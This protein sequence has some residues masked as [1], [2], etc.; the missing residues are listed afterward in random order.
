MSS[1]KQESCKD[2]FAGLVH[3]LET[4]V[5]GNPNW[6]RDIGNGVTDIQLARIHDNPTF[7]GIDSNPGKAKI[8]L[9]YI[10]N[11]ILIIGSSIP[12]N[13]CEIYINKKD[14]IP[15]DKRFSLIYLGDFEKE[16][17]P[18][19]DKDR[20]FTRKGLENFL[21]DKYN[22]GEPDNLKI[23]TDEEM[24]QAEIV[25]KANLEN[26]DF[27]RIVKEEGPLKVLIVSDDEQ[28]TLRGKEVL[29]SLHQNGHRLF[30]IYNINTTDFLKTEDYKPSTLRL[31]V[32][33]CDWRNRS[34]TI[35]SSSGLAFLNTY[36]ARHKKLY[37]LLVVNTKQN[38]LLG[39]SSLWDSLQRIVLESPTKLTHAIPYPRG[40]Q[41]DP[42]RDAR[43]WG[44]LIKEFLYQP[45]I[46]TLY[47]LH[48]DKKDVR[49]SIANLPVQWPLFNA[50]IKSEY[51]SKEIILESLERIKGWDPAGKEELLKSL[52]P[53][54][55]DFSLPQN[56]YPLPEQLGPLKEEEVITVLN[57]TSLDNP[58][59]YIHVPFCKKKCIYCDYT[60]IEGASKK[61]LEAYLKLLIRE[62]EIFYRS[63]GLQKL[64]PVSIQFGGG[65][66]TY[67]TSPLIKRLGKIAEKYLDLS[68]CKEITFETTPTTATPGKLDAY[69]TIGANRCSIGLQ[70][71]V[72]HLN[73]WSNR[74]YPSKIAE[75]SVR[76]VMKRW[77]NVNIDFMYGFPGQTP[78][79]WVGDLEQIISM[80]I[81]SIHCYGLRRTDKTDYPPSQEFPGIL[82]RM[83]MYV[84]AVELLTNAGYSQISDSNFVLDPEK[85]AYIYKHNKKGGN[86][87]IGIGLSSYSTIFGTSSDNGLFYFNLGGKDNRCSSNRRNYSE[88]LKKG[89]LPIE[90]GKVLDLDDKMKMF[91][92]QGLKLSGVGDSATGIDTTEFEN[93]YGVSLE[94]K[95]PH[96]KDL[97]DAGLLE[98][99]GDHISLS[100]SGLAFGDLVLKTYLR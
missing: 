90:I 97:L 76:E 28:Y 52:Q 70:T 60:V 53:S 82:P 98:R 23:V 81:P 17:I 65:T 25:A 11:R 32:L 27:P 93:R 39:E 15:P 4:I 83:L 16:K 86:P 51:P 56:I 89:T 21:L 6:L 61:D 26:R 73:L 30:D 40:S 36:L 57:S 63:T 49:R 7:L 5:D 54:N 75:R 3:S 87:N 77:D 37:T 92:M 94:R 45:M 8:V 10:V 99:K 1:P 18:F 19:L 22:E 47:E 78:L 66:P 84:I 42:E 38:E 69:K 35:H 95:F 88:A 58:S 13:R 68:Q 71:L 100:Y 91:V 79:L 44:R 46:Q 33:I 41:N 55:K 29:S 72:E 74:R 43:H 24:A 34:D 64:K 31:D 85:N 50:R 9:D 59:L 48:T 62:F 80:G 20:I 12:L 67:Y 2:P 96:T 14:D